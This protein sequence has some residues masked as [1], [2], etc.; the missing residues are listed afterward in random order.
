MANTTKS[1]TPRP[2][3]AGDSIHAGSSRYTT[4]ARARDRQC[5]AVEE[6][7]QQVH[8]DY[9]RHARQLDRRYHGPGTITHRYPVG[10]VEQVLLDH[11]WTRGLVFGAYGEW[12]WDVEWLLEE[13][14]RAAAQ[15]DWR[16]MGVVSRDVA[17]GFLVA[18]YRRR[19]GVVAVREMARHRYRQSQMVGL[20]RAQLSGIA[21]EA[22]RHRDGEARGEERA[23]RAVEMAQERVVPAFELQGW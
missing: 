18:S 15:R 4:H 12:S 22:Q 17:Y 14:A 20:T 5:G 8:P 13:A 7:A 11:V 2:G 3:S 23:E 10:P 9:V 6:R 19:M 1:R 21:R 16:R